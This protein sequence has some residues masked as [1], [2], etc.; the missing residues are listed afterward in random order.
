M[1]R[2]PINLTYLVPKH[3]YTVQVLGHIAHVLVQ[4]KLL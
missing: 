2:V 1:G 3:G 4:A